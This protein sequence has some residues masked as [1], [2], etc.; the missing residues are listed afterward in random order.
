MQEPSEEPVNS[1]GR[2]FFTEI[3]ESNIRQMVR[4]EIHTFSETMAAFLKLT[5]R[6]IPMT[7]QAPCFQLSAEKFPQRNALI[8][9]QSQCTT[10]KMVV[11][12]TLTLCKDTIINIIFRVG[13]GGYCNPGKVQEFRVAFK[14]SLRQYD[15]SPQQSPR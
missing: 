10:D 7:S 13:N 15:P 5:T 11:A 4:V 14:N 2:S 3:L 8:L 9:I 6:Q 1:T 12:E